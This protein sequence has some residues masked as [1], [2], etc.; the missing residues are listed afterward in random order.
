M[1]LLLSRPS[2]NVV[3]TTD[4]TYFTINVIWGKYSFKPLIEYYVLSSNNTLK[5][6]EWLNFC[7]QVSSSRDCNASELESA[8]LTCWDFQGVSLN[9]PKITKLGT[10]C[11]V[12]KTDDSFVVCTTKGWSATQNECLYEYTCNHI[13]YVLITTVISKTQA[14]VINFV[15]GI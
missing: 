10:M 3:D 5:L 11:K 12:S 1:Q 6:L 13:P 8:I 7:G 4:N 9:S 15:F 2:N 14:N